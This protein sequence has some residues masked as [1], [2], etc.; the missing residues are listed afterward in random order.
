MVVVLVTGSGLK[1]PDKVM[2]L[3]ESGN[4]GGGR[5]GNRARP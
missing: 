3:Y 4:R 5:K 1:E 2:K